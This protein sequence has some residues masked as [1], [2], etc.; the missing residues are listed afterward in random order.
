MA[1]YTPV[2]AEALEALLVHY[3]LE[4]VR[5]LKGIAEGIEN[6]NYL[7]ETARGRFILTLYEKRVKAGD[8]PYFMALLHHLSLKGVP[9]ATPRARRD[10]GTVSTLCGKPAA[11][12]TFLDGVSVTRPSLAQAHEA[13]R[14][15]AAMHWAAAD[16]PLR[17]ANDLWLPGLARIAAATAGRAH[18]V[19][20]GLGRL[21][22]DELEAQAAHDTRGLPHGPIHADLF[23]DNVL[24][25]GDRLTGLI[26]FY[27]ACDGLFAYDLAIMLNA[28]A[29]H[30][31]A[32]DTAIANAIISGYERI[33]TLTPG[34]RAAIPMLA[35]AAALRFL[36]TRLHDWLNPAPDALVKPKDPR[37]YI[38][39]LAW[40]RAA[41]PP[42]AYGFP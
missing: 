30:D 32:L 25:L 26:D 4:D 37:D 23:P 13:G 5:S 41:P 21:I 42:A 40:H 35:R 19:A 16:F 6:T 29:F 18:E 9:V 7:L 33:R 15:L 36:L 3:D 11:I 28:W 20:P 17:R 12:L 31:G 38:T 2:S 34:G 14:A 1:V 8:L 27:F 24:F 10:G 39:I 22:A